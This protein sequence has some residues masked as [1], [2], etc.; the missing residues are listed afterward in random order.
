MATVGERIKE[1]RQSHQM[2][3]EVFSQKICVSRPHIS[4]LECGK[5]N[6]SPSVI[7]LISLLFDVDE[8]W[9]RF[10]ENEKKIS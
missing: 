1:V 3:Q 2:S 4:L 6:P 8:D 7:R 10:G 5:H 9:L